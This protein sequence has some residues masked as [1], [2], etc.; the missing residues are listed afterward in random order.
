[1][2]PL[3]GRRVLVTRPRGQAAELSEPL[4]AAGAEVLA[5]ALIRIEP[6][7]DPQPLRDAAARAH[8]FDWI[9]LTSANAVDALMGAGFQAAARRAVGAAR[10]CAVGPSTAAHLKKQGLAADLVADEA[11]AEGVIAAMTASGTVGGKSILIPRADIGRDAIARA[12]SE[13][14]ALV[15]EVI[16]YQ[17][18][19]EQTVPDAV[20][21]ALEAGRVD[22]TTFTS[23][24]AVRALAGMLGADRTRS[25][26]DRSVV[27][28]IGPTTA[29]AARRA[30]LTVAIQP[31]QYTVPALVDAIVRYFRAG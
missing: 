20:L 8:A 29:D 7:S 21:R 5:A 1:V 19:A 13:A 3:A 10:F 25:L 15:T 4:A 14:G 11:R 12:L 2:K 31:T 18:V 26:L 28:V 9:V 27:A 30:G 16:A 17:T 23:G 24:S 22:V 6:P